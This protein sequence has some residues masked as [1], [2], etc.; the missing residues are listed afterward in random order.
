MRRLPSHQFNKKTSRIAAPV[1]E[2]G[3]AIAKEAAPSKTLR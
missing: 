1:A 2:C 3:L